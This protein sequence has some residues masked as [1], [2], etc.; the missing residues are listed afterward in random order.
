MSLD[1]AQVCVAHEAVHFLAVAEEDAGRHAH[2]AE[3]RGGLLGV[4][5]VDL[6]DRHLPVVVVRDLVDGRREG[7]ARSA[8]ARREVDEDRGRGGFQSALEVGV[9][10]FVDHGVRWGGAEAA[11]L[12]SGEFR[13]SEASWQACDRTAFDPGPGKLLPFRAR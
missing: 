7:L 5:D 12:N 13:P 1:R 6:V 8:P 4:V 9:V 10:E 3:A 2:D 11:P